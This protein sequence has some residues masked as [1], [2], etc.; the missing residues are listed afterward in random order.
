MRSL[1][2][3]SFPSVRA[4]EFFEEILIDEYQDSNPVQEMLLESISGEFAG[5]FNR[6]MV[7]D[8]KQSIYKFRPLSPLPHPFP[9]FGSEEVP[10]CWEK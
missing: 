9:P 5:R 8:V 10:Y 6:F 7:G 3:P 1:P 4:R 2:P